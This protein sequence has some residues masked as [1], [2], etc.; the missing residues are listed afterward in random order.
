MDFEPTAEQSALVAQVRE[1]IRERV[2]PMEGDPR[3]TAHGPTEALRGDLVAMAREAGLLSLHVSAEYGGKG[4][5]HRTAALVFEEAGYSMLGPV[6]MNIAA[7]DEANMHMLERI[8]S[9]TQKERYLRP[10]AA[11][12]GRSCFCMTE[13]APGAGSDP[14]ALATTARQEGDEFV[15]DGLKWMITGFDGAAFAII[16]ART[17]DAEGRDL[18][19]SMFLT[20]MDV[21]G[22][23]LV[24]VLDTMD[25]SFTGGHAELA[26]EGLRVPRDAVLGELGEGFRYAQVRL[27]P[28]RLT[29]CMRWLGAARRAHDIAVDYTRRREAFGQR[30]IDHEGV[31]F[32]L[33]DNEIE[34]RQARLAIWHTAWL[35]DR[36][37]RASRESSMAKVYC[38]EAIYR[39]A[40]RAMQVMGGLGLSDDTEVARIYRDVR[41]FRV[42]DG[43]SEVHRW[44]IARRLGR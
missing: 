36:G 7:P 10:L 38:A 40:D 31:G 20:P 32:Q 29:H 19:A 28:A 35:L 11:G 13:P 37:E 2:I 41:A 9:A 16:I 39:I 15:I 1:F 30:L 43:P 44:S 4:I 17:I 6:A 34:L 8:A 27:A 12:G 14:A 26:F 21:P 33:A 3:R 42:Y 25:A 18:G 22:I 5:D 24:R 23:R